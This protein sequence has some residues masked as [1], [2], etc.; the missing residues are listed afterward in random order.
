MVTL[1]ILLTVAVAL[2]LEKR[3]SGREREERGRT[4]PAPVVP[5]APPLGAPFTRRRAP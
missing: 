4:G 1:L 2:A 3:R 5:C